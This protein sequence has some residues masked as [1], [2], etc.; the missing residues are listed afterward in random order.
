MGLFDSI[1]K[2]KVVA[3]LADLLGPEIYSKFEEK[4]KE[5]LGRVSDV[6]VKPIDMNVYEI[7]FT[8]STK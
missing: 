4:L 3:Y 1:A 8:F 7:R 5:G 6:S 2:N